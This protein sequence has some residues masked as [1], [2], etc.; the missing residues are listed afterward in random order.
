YFSTF[1]FVGFVRCVYAPAFVLL[2]WALFY[3]SPRFRAAPA[4][5]DGFVI[6]QVHQ[7][8]ADVSELPL[9]DIPAAGVDFLVGADKPFYIE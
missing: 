4:F 2:V 6:V 9:V 3:F 7:L 1:L 8:V 5:R